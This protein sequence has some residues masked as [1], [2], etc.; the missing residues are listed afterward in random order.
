MS[1]ARKIEERKLES[2]SPLRACLLFQ[3]APDDAIAFAEER[4]EEVFFKR[5]ECIILENESN[6]SVYFII[7]GSVE[8]VNY[9]AEE[10][11]IQRLGLLKAG[12]NFAEFSI[13]TKSSRSGSAYA[14]EDCTLLRMQGDVFLKVL[15]QFPAVALKLA[16]ISASINL[17]VETLNEVIPFYNPSQLLVSSEVATLLPIPMWLKFGVIPVSLKSGLLTVILKNPHNQDFFRYMRGTLPQ[18]EFALHAIGESEFDAALQTAQENLKSGRSTSAAKLAA[19]NAA[20]NASA[21]TTAGEVNVLEILKVSKLFSSLPES[22][23]EQIATRVQPVPL[24]AGGL[25]LKPASEVTSYILVAK[26]QLLLQQPLHQSGLANAWAPLMKV[27]V[28]EGIGEVQILTGG[29]YS[30]AARALEDTVLIPVPASILQQLFQFPTFTVPLASGL[31][32]RLQVL[33]H[34]AGM[35][36]FKAQANIDFK[37]VAH[38][39]PLSLMTEQKII[40]LKIQDQEVV[41]GAVNPDSV[42]LLSRISRYFKGYRLQL[43]SVREEQFQSWLTQLTPHLETATEKLTART[44]KFAKQAHIDVV[45]WIDQIILTGMKNRSSDIHF[46]PTEDH[47]HVRYRVDGVLQEY[48]ERLDAEI[49]HEAIN[50]LKIISDMDISLKAV[51]QDGQ[52]KTKIDD[53]E[54]I[55]RASSVPV[56]QGEK[57]VLRLIRSQSAVMPLAMIAPD[58]RVVNILNAVT[59]S[60]QGLFLVTGPTGSGKTTT[61]YSL[62]NAINDVGVNV[63]TLEDPVE[64]EIKG[65]NQIEVDQKRG[66]TFGA[67]L[68]AVLR[69]D[70]N[71]IM[72]GE[73][74][75]EESAKIV[76]DAS[77]TGHLVLSTLHTTSSLDIAPRL[78]ELG[79]SSANIAAGLLGVLTQRLLRAN[80]KKCLTQ[81]PTTQSERAVFV[82]I[83]GMQNPPAELAHSPGCPACNNTGYLRRVPVLEV[84]R[85]SP[86]MQ[87]ALL[88]KKSGEDLMKIARQDGF[89]ALQEAGLRLVLS[90]VT[91]LEEVRRVLGGF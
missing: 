20:T 64:M 41:L 25:A 55:A 46:E 40:P 43:F 57:F 85:N 13:L 5:G 76:F 58:R 74:R 36:F 31:A 35:S 26:G 1:A 4:I 52:L 18:V 65:F 84:W 77:I 15:R 17:S 81:R 29:K 90:G 39:L 56:R 11:R 42:N 66:L 72:V 59:R 47:L 51:P 71:V 83:L 89:E 50:R 54:V 75:D 16:K 6:N 68:R 37:G 78:L 33:G 34:I 23:L 12:S 10:N 53:V 28:G 79:V 27:G 14:F 8:I 7:H 70:P 30:Y 60:R 21:S 82:E 2:V 38:L 69:Q 19:V 86:A 80:C 63:T 3:E 91:S 22:L 62:L 87:R 45:K 49:G 9:L 61:L 88:E 32:K 73:I 44:G 67:A 48:N 24:K